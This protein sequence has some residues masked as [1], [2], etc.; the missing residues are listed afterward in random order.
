MYNIDGEMVSGK[1]LRDMFMD[2]ISKI[3]SLGE[4][5][6]V[7]KF[8]TNGKVDQVKLSRYL[9]DQLGSKNANASVLEAVETKETNDGVEMNYPLA[10]TTSSSWIEAIMI[11]TVNG[12]VIDINTPGSSFVQRSV[13]A[14]ESEDGEGAIQGMNFY[15]G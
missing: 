12:D 15:H 14:I 1:V 7:E 9:K 3:S 13:F 10:A 2:H 5:K 11:A 6:I 4:Q 8:F